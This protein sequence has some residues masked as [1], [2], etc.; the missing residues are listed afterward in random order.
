MLIPYTCPWLSLVF[1]GTGCCEAG[2]WE[3]RYEFVWALDSDIDLSK[4]G[5]WSLVVFVSSNCVVLSP[6]TARFEPVESLC[7]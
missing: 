4:A 2:D 6:F 7:T 3:K 1:S 5:H